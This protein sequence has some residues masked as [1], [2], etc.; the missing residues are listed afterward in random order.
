MTEQASSSLGITVLRDGLALGEVYEPVFPDYT[1]D[2][3][4]T[5]AQNNIG[6]VETKTVTW[7]RTGDLQFNLR[8][9]GSAAQA[10]LWT[11]FHNRTNSVWG[12][13]MPQTS[14]LSAHSYVWVG[15][16]SKMTPIADGT[17]TIGFS[18]EVTVNGAIAHITTRADGLT[19]PFFSIVDDGAAAL[20]PS[21]SASATVYEYTVQAYSNST[22]VAIT[23]TATAGTI[24]VNGTSVATGAASGAININAGTG[25]ITMIPIVVTELNKTPRIYWLRIVIGTTARP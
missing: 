6:G 16:I 20:N 4:D 13:V 24:Y 1:A 15:Q 8:N 7:I 12:F 17:E 14:G 10:A 5:S 22:T 3:A 2:K 23:P 18:M 25:A 19:T 9:V 21:P 11:A